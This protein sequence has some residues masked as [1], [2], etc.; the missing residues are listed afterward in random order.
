M[1]MRYWCSRRHDWDGI[2]TTA[3]HN[4]KMTDKSPTVETEEESLKEEEDPHVMSEAE[5][6]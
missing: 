5:E 1:N 4:K 2:L 3:N 6:S